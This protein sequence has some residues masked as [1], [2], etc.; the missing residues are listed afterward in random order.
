[1]TA[2]EKAGYKPGDD[3]MIALDPAASSFYHAE[4][5]CYILEG[6]GGRELDPTAWV[7]STRRS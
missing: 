4:K 1:M 3:I 2:I 6:E 7:D 5:K